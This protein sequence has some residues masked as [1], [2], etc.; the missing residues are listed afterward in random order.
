MAI[1]GF[2]ATDLLQRIY[3]NR[4][5]ATDLS[6]RICRNGFI[7]TDLSQRICRNGFIATDLSQRIYR[8]GFVATDLSQRIYWL[9]FY[10]TGY[11]FNPIYST[12]FCL[13]LV[14]LSVIFYQN[15]KD[16][17]RCVIQ[18]RLL[19]NQFI[20]TLSSHFLISLNTRT[21]TNQISIAISIVHSSYRSPKLVS[22][23]QVRQWIS[24]F[25]SGIRKF[26]IISS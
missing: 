20:I 24:C 14:S 2:V 9:L 3:R 22:F 25:F 4:F 1:N 21:S 26:P 12:A 18:N 8:N 15:K 13:K 16:G 11:L 23:F 10:L 17:F 5:V 6:Q 7:A 19:L